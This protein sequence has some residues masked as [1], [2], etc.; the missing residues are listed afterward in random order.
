LIWSSSSGSISDAALVAVAAGL[1]LVGT[2]LGSGGHVTHWLWLSLL[3]LIGWFAVGALI[4]PFL[5]AWL[6]RQDAKQF[7]DR[8]DD[9]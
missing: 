8:S 1:H 2:L 4:G 3:I 9:T 6:D 7:T 5:G